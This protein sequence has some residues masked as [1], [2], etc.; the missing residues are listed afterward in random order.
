M[1]M[2]EE[3]RTKTRDLIV[4]HMS[5][6]VEDPTAPTGCR[7][8]GAHVLLGMMARAEDAEAEAVPAA[9]HAKAMRVVT[10]LLRHPEAKPPFDAAHDAYE[11]STGKRWDE[12]S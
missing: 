8:D 10:E 12:E 5:R 2:S 11:A 6:I 1:L 7:I 9:V 3:T 4:K